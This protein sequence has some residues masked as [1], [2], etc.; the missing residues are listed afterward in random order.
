MTHTCTVTWADKSPSTSQHL[1]IHGNTVHVTACKTGVKS[2]GLSSLSPC[3][4][5]WIGIKEAVGT[6]SPKTTLRRGCNRKHVL[7]TVNNVV[8]SQLHLRLLEDRGGRN[9]L[10]GKPQH[11]I[12]CPNNTVTTASVSHSLWGYH[13]AH[14]LLPGLPLSVIRSLGRC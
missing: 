11:D 5:Q 14:K 3:L 1:Q 10:V 6:A 12:C 2:A 7:C 8:Q 9:P 4:S 13:H